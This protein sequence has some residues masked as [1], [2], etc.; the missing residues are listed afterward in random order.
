LVAA[1]GGGGVAER[2]ELAFQELMVLEQNVE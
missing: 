1:T 2:P